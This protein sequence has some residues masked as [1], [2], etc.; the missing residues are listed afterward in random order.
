VVGTRRL[1]AMKRSP[2]CR[3][4]G[5]MACV[6]VLCSELDRSCRGWWLRLDRRGWTD[7]LGLGLVM[8]FAAMA[9]ACQHIEPPPAPAAVVEPPPVP[10]PPA[11]PVVRRNIQLAWSFAAGPGRCIATASGEKA[12]L[13]AGITRDSPV[14]LTVTLAPPGSAQIS[15][16]STATFRFSG[17]AG[18][19]LIRASGNPQHRL[20]ASA[21]T[22]ELAIARILIL[23]G[24]GT[25]YVEGTS[26]SPLLL[27]VPAA[28]EPGQTWS[29]CASKQVI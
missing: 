7:M 28:G 2:L 13:T 17:A 26:L 1:P 24:G 21:G 15:G 5:P 27:Q 12:S 10:I 25:L 18:S 3:R 6:A 4:S 19:W 20:T 11:R 8:A 9:G 22:D 29:E 16:R 14:N 23:L